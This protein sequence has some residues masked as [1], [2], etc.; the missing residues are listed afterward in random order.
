M[1]DKDGLAYRW[2]KLG[3]EG[4]TT[5]PNTFRSRF[6]GNITSLVSFMTKETHNIKPTRSFTFSSRIRFTAER[7]QKEAS[8]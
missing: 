3:S 8:W 2:S 4:T 6:K 5:R 7:F 1:D